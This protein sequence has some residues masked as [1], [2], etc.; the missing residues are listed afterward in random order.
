M[1]YISDI[2]ISDYSC[3]I[4]EAALLNIPL[5]FYTYDYEKYMKGASLHGL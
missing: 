2:V 4:Y 1:L 3:I 5:Y